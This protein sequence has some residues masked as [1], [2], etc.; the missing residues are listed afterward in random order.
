MDADKTP[1][2]QPTKSFAFGSSETLTL[3]THAAEPP[4][5]KARVEPWPDHRAETAPCAERHSETGSV[6]AQPEA[7]ARSGFAGRGP[8]HDV[9]S[10]GPVGAT[11]GRRAGRDGRDQNAP[12]ASSAQNG[13]RGAAGSDPV[14]TA[15][16][17]NL[18]EPQRQ[19]N[20]ALPVHPHQTGG[21]GSNFP[22][23][24]R[25]FGQVLGG[26]ARVR[27][28]RV[29][30]AFPAA[31]Q[32]GAYVLG[33]GRHCADLTLAGAQVT[34]AHRRVFG[35]QPVSGG[36]GRLAAPVFDG[37]YGRTLSQFLRHL[38]KKSAQGLSHQ[39]GQITPKS[40]FFCQQNLLNPRKSLYNNF[41]LIF[42]IMAGMRM[43]ALA[44]GFGAA[45]A[46]GP[47][48]A[49]AQA[50]EIVI[51]LETG[52]EIVMNVADVAHETQTAIMNHLDACIG[53]AE[54]TR[55][56]CVA[57]A[58][59]LMATEKLD[60]VVRETHQRL[61]PLSEAIAIPVADLIREP[62]FC[63]YAPDDDAI[64]SC[65]QDV[66]ALQLAALDVQIS[67]VRE[68]RIG[69]ETREA[70]IDAAIERE[71]V[72]NVTRADRNEDLHN[73]LSDVTTERDTAEDRERRAEAGIENILKTRVSAG[74]LSHYRSEATKIIEAEYKGEARTK[75]LGT[76][77]KAL[78][79]H[80]A[81]LSAIQSVFTPQEVQQVFGGSLTSTVTLN[82]AAQSNADIYRDLFTRIDAGFAGDDD[83]R[84][85][86]RA[87]VEAQLG[88][89]LR[90]VE[91]PNNATELQET[92]REGRGTE[93]VQVG[94][95][96]VEDPPGSGNWVEQ[97]VYEEQVIPFTPQDKLMLSENP[98]VGLYPDPPGSTNYRVEGEVTGADPIQF[99]VDIPEN[100]AIPEAYINREF[101][102]ALIS[103]NFHNSGLRGAMEFLTTGV[104]AT[105]PMSTDTSR[106]AIGQND[107][108]QK[109]FEVFHGI[110]FPLEGR[111]AT[112]AELQSSQNDLRWL[113]IDGDLGPTNQ[114]DP[115]RSVALMRAVFG[116]SQEEIVAS[117]SQ[118]QSVI[119]TGGVEAPSIQRLYQ[120]LYP[121]D[122]A[123]G[124][125]RL[126]SII[127]DDGLAML[128]LDTD[129]AV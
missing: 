46:A 113:A 101:N 23:A 126:R 119:N 127:G 58:A 3:N 88:I 4:I 95:E 67:E 25:R 93:R 91:R 57:E 55:D 53:A 59:T 120:A 123:N 63:H 5:K 60:G 108:L 40:N 56:E 104:D 22:T 92:L 115:T 114:I 6:P 52:G 18:A 111:F 13:T 106:G 12:S 45:L 90:E 29:F 43:T 19:A 65:S 81:N 34:D 24:L 110:N 94:T 68:R 84:R 8:R 74:S 64:E 71:Q 77:D 2:K 112:P 82:L 100:G 87:Q 50:T 73:T 102:K 125:P 97:P 7:L 76:L 128:D 83:R 105:L 35:H 121:N 42:L 98:A 48:D 33:G 17:E 32:S 117:M 99:E 70:Q 41:V 15:L 62:V 44:A 109:V 28:G 75:A 61:Q 86:V 72:A 37:R 21:R 96:T 26:V 54:I 85:E 38:N 122:A 78:V 79:K 116:N 107:V 10:N 80:E 11:S 47:D 14:H 39:T 1:Q 51:P 66:E 27:P 20:G 49:S 9:T 118:A 30:Y 16:S 69:A 89:Q 36:T 103:A 124:Y 31:H 129:T